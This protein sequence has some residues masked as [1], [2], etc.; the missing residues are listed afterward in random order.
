[1]TFRTSTLHLKHSH[2]I[3]AMVDPG[4]CRI[5]TGLTTVNP[6]PALLVR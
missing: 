6:L 4:R 5:T 2:H 3:L 1:M